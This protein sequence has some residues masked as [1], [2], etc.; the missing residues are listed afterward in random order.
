MNKRPI[1][2]IT[3]ATGLA[4]RALSKR[5]LEKGHKLR[6]LVLESDPLLADFI[7]TCPDINSVEVCKGD[8]SNY[9]SIAPYFNGVS[10]VYHVA[11]LVTGAHPKSVYEKVNVLGTKMY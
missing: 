5:L 6:I 11:A 8:I 9:E 10:C 4:G 2:L 3:G 7:S 1:S